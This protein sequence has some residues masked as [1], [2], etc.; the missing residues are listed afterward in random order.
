MFD[1]SLPPGVTDSIG[2]KLGEK[3][4]DNLVK[5]GDTLV[6][7]TLLARG[8]TFCLLAIAAVWVGAK[9]FVAVHQELYGTAAVK[10]DVAHRVSG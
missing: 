1:I 9:A 8:P 4:T 2:E 7:L 5:F 3:A 10:H 6:K